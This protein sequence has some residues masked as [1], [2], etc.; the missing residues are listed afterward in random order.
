MY[1]EKITYS[2][3][4]KIKNELEKRYIE[5]RNEYAKLYKRYKRRK[6]RG[7]EYFLYAWGFEEGRLQ[8]LSGFVSAIY[9]YLTK[10]H[11]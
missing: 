4:L 6:A 11:N 1:N 2:E 5:L 9:D 8:A 7:T 3:L 10:G